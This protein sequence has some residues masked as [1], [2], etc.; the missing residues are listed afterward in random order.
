MYV[1]D[2]Q[3]YLI[4]TSYHVPKLIGLKVTTLVNGEKNLKS[5]RD[6]DIDW[7]MPNIELIAYFHML[8]YIRISCS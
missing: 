6:R 8:K 2:E 1:S 4:T 5:C 3:A 7:T